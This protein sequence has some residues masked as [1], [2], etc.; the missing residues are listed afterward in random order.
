MNIRLLTVLFSFLALTITAQNKDYQNQASDYQIIP[1]VNELH[2]QNGRFVIDENTK[3]SGDEALKNEGEYLAEMLSLASGFNMKF[4]DKKGNIQ[5]ILDPSIENDEGYQLSIRY[6]K[7]T[8]TGKTPKGVFYGIQTLRQLMPA[9][10]E[11]EH[12]SSAT[13]TIPAVDIADAPRFS[14][15]GM[16]L[17]VGRHF[18]SV[19]FIKTYIDMIALHKM[20]TFHWHLTED[21]GWRIEIKKYPKLTEIGAWRK[22]TLIGHMS[23]DK[24]DLKYDGQRYG[25]FYTQEQIKDIVAYAQERHITIIPE[26]DLPGHSTAAL[27]AYPEFGNFGEQHEVGTNWG[28]YYQIYAPT[29]ETFAFLEDILSEVAD[30]FP[31]EYIHIGGDEALKDEWKKSEYAQELIKKEGLG[32]ENGLQS[33]FI[34]RISQF[35]KTKNKK[36]IG[37]DE[38]IEG[39]LAPD[40]TVMYWRSRKGTDEIVEM[41]EEGHHI[42]MTPTSYCYFDYYQVPKRMQKKEDLCIG[43]YLTAE[44]VYGFEPM[45]EKISEDAKKNIIGAQ[46]NVWT[47]YIKTPERVEYMALPRMTALSEVVWSKKENK[48]WDDFQKRLLH[49]TKRYDALGLKY[50]KHELK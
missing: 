40:A 36:I 15:R 8:I 50:S 49:L 39:G 46:G 9:T 31:S 30:L 43:G 22:E 35:L 29:E 5:L 27:A 4:S 42:I 11:A 6:N 48:D 47:E 20:N 26:I 14:Y 16:H 44:K 19:D 18:F 38:I 23:G 21:Q 13:I 1:Q 37:W 32:D 2:P 28:V 33:Y 17:D 34:K 7:I 45:P 41:A 10:I 3:I 25:G 24:K 12:G